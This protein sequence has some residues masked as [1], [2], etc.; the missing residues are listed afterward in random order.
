[1]AAD[2][3]I[4]REIEAYKLANMAAQHR[5]AGQL[6]ELVI[7][8]LVQ[9]VIDPEVKH[10]TKVQAAKVLGTVTEV[11]AFTERKETRVIKSSGDIRAQ[12]MDQLKAI[13]RNSATDAV[14]VDAAG[15]L[16]DLAPSRFAPGAPTDTPT[17]PFSDQESQDGPHT[18]PDTLSS[19]KSDIQ[20]PEVSNTL[21]SEESI[22]APPPPSQNKME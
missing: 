18:I 14:E 3:R 21:S 5:T 4:Q 2:P 11:A 17:P 15:L 10:A 19:K 1:M 13:M 22:L 8:S 9:V 7:Q 20:S 6:R 12:I 16:E